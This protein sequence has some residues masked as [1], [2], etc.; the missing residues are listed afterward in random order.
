MSLAVLAKSV[1]NALSAVEINFNRLAGR[2]FIPAAPDML[3]VETSS[4]CNLKCRFCAYEKKQSPKVS[5]P[6]EFFRNCIRQATAMGYRQFEL[7]P[8]TGDIFMDRHIFNKLQYLQDDP[9]VESFQFF[10]N[11]TI[12]KTKD[13]ERIFKFDKLQ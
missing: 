11:F 5:M 3:F 9:A 13:I 2:E 4:L 6:D 12:P 8:C 10:T 7:T 1:R